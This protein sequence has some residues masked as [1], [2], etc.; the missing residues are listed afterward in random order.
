MTK[1]ELA[2]LDKLEIA[3]DVVKGQLPSLWAGVR[4]LCALVRERSGSLNRQ[5]ES[6]AD[7]IAARQAARIAELEALLG[8][9][10]EAVFTTERS[11]RRG[12]DVASQDEPR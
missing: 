1:D 4:W 10:P 2:E 12:P 5:P 6:K 7:E 3:A 11:R 8:L 9:T